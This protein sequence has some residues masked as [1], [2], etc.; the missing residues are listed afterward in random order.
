M[1]PE[2]C[3]RLLGP[4]DMTMPTSLS[5][6]VVDMYHARTE[7][8]LEALP[9]V[10]E[11]VRRACHGAQVLV[12]ANAKVRVERALEALHRLHCQC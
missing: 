1:R 10:V 4:A 8:Q 11:G 6:F 7:E 3:V 2:A 12:F 5:H 9:E